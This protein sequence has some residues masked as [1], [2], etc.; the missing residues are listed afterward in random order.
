MK[1]VLLSILALF[2]VSNLAFATLTVQQ[3]RSKEQLTNSGYSNETAKVV[4]IEAGEYNVKPTN[5]W[6]K[7]GFKIWD[8]I[9]PAAPKARDDIKHDIKPFT[10][11]DDL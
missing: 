7:A 8:Y 3:V 5:N 11:F 2:V 4:Q 6:Q 10:Y 9:D 1:K